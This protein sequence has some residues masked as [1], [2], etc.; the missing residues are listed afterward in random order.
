[1]KKY[2]METVVGLFVCLGLLCVAYL[3]VQLGRMQLFGGDEYSLYA[4][5]T[6]ISGLKT[7]ARLEIAGVSVGHVGAIGL[8]SD[9]F[10][11]KV[12]LRVKNGVVVSEDTIASI[13]TSGLI[14][15]K[16]VKLSPGGSDKALKPGARVADTESAVDVEELISKYAFGKV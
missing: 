3:T 7:G 15:D 16:Y 9:D 1:M 10:T 13:K 4:N 6:N 14:G 2:Q 5:F 11:A 12:E 8:N